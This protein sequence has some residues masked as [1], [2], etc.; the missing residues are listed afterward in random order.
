[1][2]ESF[3]QTKEFSEL[4]MLY[5]HKERKLKKYR[6]VYILMNV[7]QYGKLLLTNASQT[8]VTSKYQMYNPLTFQNPF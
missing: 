2:A 8:N 6:Q 7:Y 4:P 1:M 3:F 5:I